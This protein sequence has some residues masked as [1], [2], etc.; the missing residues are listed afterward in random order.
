MLTRPGGRRFF[1]ASLAAGRALPAPR[2]R[3]R[4]KLRDGHDNRTTGVAWLAPAMGVE[5]HEHR[6]VERAAN[7]L[8]L[9]ELKVGSG[10]RRSQSPGPP[11]PR[12][13]RWSDFHARGFVTPVL[14]PSKPMSNKNSKA[15]EPGKRHQKGGY[16]CP[17]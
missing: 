13:A 10:G 7:G 5:R 4:Q 14:P 2:R 8:Y 1:A 17:F 16:L 12:T 6:V 3:E 11:S 15:A 9:N